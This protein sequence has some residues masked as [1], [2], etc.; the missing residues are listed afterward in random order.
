MCNY[1]TTAWFGIYIWPPLCM[2]HQRNHLTYVLSAGRYCCSTRG[3]NTCCKYYYKL[4]R[5]IK[6]T[7]SKHTQ[8]IFVLLGG[9]IKL[10]SA[11]PCSCCF[12]VYRRYRYYTYT[13]PWDNL[14]FFAS[15]QTKAPVWHKNGRV[16]LHK[17]GECEAMSLC[18]YKVHT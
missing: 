8:N 2:Q 5:H 7:K 11:I 14:C 16:I 9:T 3:G 12:C 15:A 13:V 6:I 1:I 17:F 4:S 10:F 18:E